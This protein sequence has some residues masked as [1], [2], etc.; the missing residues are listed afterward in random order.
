[1]AFL[2]ALISIQAAAQKNELSITFGAERTSD[3]TV[4]FPPEVC[5]F[6][7]FTPC[8]FNGLKL[9]DKIRFGMIASYARRI[10]KTGAGD[11]YIE[12]PFFLIPPHD[13][14]QNF[15]SNIPT[16]GP[17]PTGTTLF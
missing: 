17:V 2:V 3:Q 8:V 11:L 14:R 12:A 9:I 4:T 5:P 7:T 16:G 13:I 1:M 15:I 6:I 10:V